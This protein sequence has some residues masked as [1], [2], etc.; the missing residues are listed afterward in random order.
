MT[1]TANLYIFKSGNGDKQD[2]Y[3]E[4]IKD[5]DQK[6][7]LELMLNSLNKPLD[8]QPNWDTELFKFITDNTKVEDVADAAKSLMTLTHVAEAARPTDETWESWKN[9]MDEVGKLSDLTEQETFQR[10][11]DD[12]FVKQ[13][14]ESYGTLDKYNALLEEIHKLMESDDSNR[15]AIMFLMENMGKGFLLLP[16]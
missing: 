4:I 10:L 2:A 3:E 14:R 16:K 11:S 13:G 7:L 6:K 9:L 12:V 15:Q 1:K 5:V 8:N